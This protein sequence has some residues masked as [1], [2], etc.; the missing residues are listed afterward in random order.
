MCH[1]LCVTP[2]LFYHKVRRT[3]TDATHIGYRL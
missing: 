3:S 2:G 1:W